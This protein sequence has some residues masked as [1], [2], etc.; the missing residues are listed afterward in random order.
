M[1]AQQV[2]S[3]TG[4]VVLVT[5]ASSGI[6]LETARALAAM[7]AELIVMARDPARGEAAR[8]ELTRASG[9]ANWDGT[10]NLLLCDFGDFACVR[11]TAQQVC[12]R[13]SRIDVL[14]NNAGAILPERSI[15][16]DGCERTMQTNHFSHYLLTRLLE[17]LLVAAGSSRVI[18]VSSDAHLAAYRGIPFDDLTFERRWSAFGAYSVSKLA[19]IMFAYELARRWVDSG[20]TSNAMHPGL[21]RTGFGR[22]GWGSQ[23]SLFTKLAKPFYLNAAQGAD[24]E[25]HLASSLEVE[26][27]SGRYFYRRHPKRSSRAS[28]NLEAQ[29][30]LWDESECVVGGYL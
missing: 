29:R 1:E 30:R 26:G 23:G 8:L 27:V 21:V 7:G 19:N 13:W 16:V 11:D 22:G 12:E 15:T 28:Y 24:T 6:G 2:R 4:K 14:C 17:P 9:S 20:I 10:V 18:T 25:I 5:G 3:M